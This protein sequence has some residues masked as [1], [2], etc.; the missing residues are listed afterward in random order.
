M[1][2]SGRSLRY[3]KSGMTKYPQRLV[4]VRTEGRFDFSSSAVV[5]KAR[6]DIEASLGATGRVLLRASGTEPVIRVMVEG[7][8]DAMVNESARQLADAV[9]RGYAQT[10]R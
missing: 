4:N 6:A 1:V 9:R 2:E 7:E 10:Q 8:D 5:T 3:L